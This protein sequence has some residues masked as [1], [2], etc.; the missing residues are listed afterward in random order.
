M[1]LKHS[2]LSNTN[3]KTK[4]EIKTEINKGK[5][6]HFYQTKS[7]VIPRKISRVDTP[8]TIWRHYFE[9]LE[10]SGVENCSYFP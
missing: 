4:T 6:K 9:S 8:S 1:G 3:T 7:K 2:C 10:I 5:E